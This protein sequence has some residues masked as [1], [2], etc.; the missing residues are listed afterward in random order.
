METKK[1]L[2][3]IFSFIFLGLFIFV[4]T[5]G[6][7]NF[8]KVKDSMSGTGI[9][10]ETDMNLAYEDGYNTA[11]KDKNEYTELINSYRDTITIQTDQISQLNT[12]IDNLTNENTDYSIEIDSLKQTIDINEEIISNYEV[13][14]ENNEST[15]ATLEEDIEDLNITINSLNEEIQNG[16]IEIEILENRI[17]SLNNQIESL[18]ENIGS[19]ELA[20]TNYSTQIITLSN[21]N[22]LLSAQ[23]LTLQN[24]LLSNNSQ[25]AKLNDKINDLEKSVE[26]YESYIFELENNNHF[27]GIFE[28]DGSVYD[29][30]EADDNNKVSTIN[31][32]ST[33][34]VIFNYWMVDNTQV[35]LD[36]YTLTE[37][38]KFVANVTYKYNVQ[39][40]VDDSEYDT[41]IVEGGCK[42]SIPTNPIKD[43]Y[44]FLGWSINGID[45]VDINEYEINSNTIFIAV[46]MN[47]YGLFNTDTGSLIYSWE[48]LLTYDYLNFD[49][50]TYTLTAGKNI[51]RISGDLKIDSDVKVI[52]NSTFN[53]CS[54][55]V[56]VDLTN[57]QKIEDRVFYGCASLISANFSN[58]L[59]SIGEYAFYQCSSLEEIIIPNSVVEMKRSAFGRCTSANKVILSNSLTA[60]EYGVFE[61]CEAL[62]EIEIPDSI[63][64][65]EGYSLSNTGIKEID[66]NNVTYSY[67]SFVS[68]DSLTKISIHE[69]IEYFDIIP[70]TLDSIVYNEYKGMRYLGDDTNPYLV[71][72]ESD[73]KTISQVE[74]AP[75]VKVLTN[76][77]SDCTNL[78]TITIPNS[79]VAIGSETFKSCK[80]L[81]N[82]TMSDNV[83]YI[84]SNAFSYCK[85]LTSIELSKNLLSID[86]SAFSSCSSLISIEIPTSVEKLGF[87]VFGSCWALNSVTFENGESNLK[88]MD[89]SVFYYCSKLTTIYLPESIIEI[90]ATSSSNSAFLLCNSELVVYCGADSKPENWGDYWNANNSTQFETHWGYTYEE[91][92]AGIGV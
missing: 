88:Y 27:V 85:A 8:N 4:I 74:F 86:S 89:A 3:I 35:D 37:N 53:G 90:S 13:K 61:Y 14:I 42:T 78:T 40:L 9:Y 41:Q 10:T 50:Q 60:L 77:F 75:N 82:I 64:R 47:K 58:N 5:W 67:M 56:N 49:E 79:V 30:C 11:L 80:N 84:G 91:Y 26:F 39:F 36:S 7:I 57:I 48:D 46:F 23:L 18:N 63:T 92:L 33:E 17:T 21:Q 81:S 31:P 20:N 69:C 70:S 19:L 44:D 15:I 52:G 1:V 66:I 25:I 43:K 72:V 16:N 45:I 73:D 76:T 32:Q 38:T 54:A 51:K 22:S 2:G 34:Y 87:R 55:L 68:C 24:E 12:K 6:V 28:F 62:T 29:I 59:T 65:L 71:M 83:K